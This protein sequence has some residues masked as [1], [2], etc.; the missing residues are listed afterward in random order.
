MAPPREYAIVSEARHMRK[1]FSMR[2]VIISAFISLTLVA[3]VFILLSQVSPPKQEKV[4][5]EIAVP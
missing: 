2:T 5:K 3:G 1:T 4:V